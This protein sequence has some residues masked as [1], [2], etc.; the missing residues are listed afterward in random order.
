[1]TQDLHIHTIFSDGDSAVVPQQTVELVAFAKHADI[2]GISDH[3]ECFLADRYEEY[4]T[5]VK[6]AGLYCGV[7]VNGFKRAETVINYEFDYF[8]Y[9]CNGSEPRD[10]AGFELLLKTGKPSIIAHPYAV[11]TDLSRVPSG[12]LVEINNRYVWRYDWRKELGPYVDKF[13]WVFGSDA[14]QPNWLSQL[15]ARR[16][17]EE[18]GVEE[19]ILFAKNMMRE[20]ALIN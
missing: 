19:T 18:L 13:R 6:K 11:G 5:A 9:H 4:Y 3:S 7:E 8:I 1:M 15:I 10:Y 20:K 12:S 2:V 14:H 17:G 16:V